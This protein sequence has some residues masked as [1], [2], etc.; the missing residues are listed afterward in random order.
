MRLSEGQ[1]LPQ[2]EVLREGEMRTPD[3]V[4]AMLRL[5]AVPA[6]WRQC[7]RGAPGAFG[8]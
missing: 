6:T 3:E 5:K 7:R 1:L 8:G 2:A 4:A